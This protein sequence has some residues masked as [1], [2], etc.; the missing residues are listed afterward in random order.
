[1]L[2]RCTSHFQVKVFPIGLKFIQAVFKP[3]NASCSTK[4][5]QLSKPQTKRN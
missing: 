3:L 4:Q 1:M 5:I 2:E